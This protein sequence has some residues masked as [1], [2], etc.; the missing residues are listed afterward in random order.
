VSTSGTIR[1]AAAVIVRDDGRT[2]L[3]RKRGTYAFMQAGGKLG[4]GEAAI[5]ALRREIGEELGCDIGGPPLELGRF[6]APAAN[7]AGHMVEAELFAV[8]LAGEVRPAAEIEDAIWHDPYDLDSIVLAPLT[9][10][11]A[12]PLARGLGRRI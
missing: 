2:L 8:T 9:R 5:D 10:D 6:R 11:H 4:E 1:I 12:L 7:E 3:V